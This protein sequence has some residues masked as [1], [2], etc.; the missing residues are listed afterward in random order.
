MRGLPTVRIP[1][2]ARQIVW[3]ISSTYQQERHRTPPLDGEQTDIYVLRQFASD[4]I[5]TGAGEWSSLNPEPVRRA[6]RR[7]GEVATAAACG[8]PNGSDAKL[9]GQGLRAKGRAAR[10]APH[11]RRANA[12]RVTPCGF[13]VPSRLGRRAE[14]GPCQLLRRV[15]RPALDAVTPGYSRACQTTGNLHFLEVNLQ[16]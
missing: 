10:G 12:R 1:L 13:S 6:S 4:V 2:V 8:A 15:S 14:A 7:V 16:P 11:L 3:S 5:G 9:H